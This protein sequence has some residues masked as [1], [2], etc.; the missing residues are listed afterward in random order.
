MKLTPQE[1]Q[2]IDAYD[3]NATVWAKSRN[4]K[5]DWAEE[6]KKLKQHVLNGKI[7]EI[8]AGGG[9]DARD[10]IDMGYDYVGTDISQGLLKE[11]QKNN[12]EAIFLLQSVYNLDF[13]DNSFNGV[14]A[15]AVLL[16]MPKD[17]IDTALQNLHR[18]MKKDGTMFISLK[19]G[20]GEKF[21][22][23]DHAG[24]QYKRFFSFY[25]M[26]EFSEILHRNNFEIVESYEMDHSNKK[27]LVFFVRK[28]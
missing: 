12:P 14:W 23:G 24:I 21:V 6:K 20:N 5:G 26:P 2:T 9:R 3:Q 25:E 18:V 7:L 28:S 15:C 1:Q 17:R 27:W 13:P 22:E 8:G 11:A 16:H 19:K 10:L 4:K